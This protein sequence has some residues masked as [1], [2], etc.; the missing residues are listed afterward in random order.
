MNVSK[1]DRNGNER[2]ELWVDC[3]IYKVW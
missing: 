1:H 3:C 2:V